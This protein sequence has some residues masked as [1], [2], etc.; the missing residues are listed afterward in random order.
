MEKATGNALTGNG[1]L[2]QDHNNLNASEWNGQQ[3]D[4]LT[5]W[6]GSDAGRISHQKIR[7]GTAIQGNFLTGKRAE[8]CGL[9][10]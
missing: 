9:L 5:K 4:F 7:G 1:L 2:D 3:L 6:L 8:V 10:Q